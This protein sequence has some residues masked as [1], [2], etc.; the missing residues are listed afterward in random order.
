MIAIR[1]I[2]REEK[3]GLCGKKIW[4][5]FSICDGDDEKLFGKDWGKRIKY[6]QKGKSI[7]IEDKLWDSLSETKQKL[8]RKHIGY[9]EQLYCDKCSYDTPEL[10]PLSKWMFVETFRGHNG[11]KRRIYHSCR[12][13]SKQVK[14]SGKDVLE[15]RVRKNLRQ[16]DKSSA[17]N[18]GTQ[19]D[20]R[21]YE[22]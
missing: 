16:L 20:I 6:T 14:V 1:C 10:K 5:G 2:W 12:G 15:L 3:C 22:R 21:V 4:Q 19:E 7:E 8:L 11:R 17:R 9:E 13:D 18:P